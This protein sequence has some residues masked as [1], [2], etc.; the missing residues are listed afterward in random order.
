MKSTLAILIFLSSFAYADDL[1]SLDLLNNRLS[2]SVPKGAKNEAR[3]H[4]IMAAPEANESETRLVFEDGEK[5]LVVMAWELFRR[6]SATYK[7]EVAKAL[8]QWSEIESA[9]FKIS[10]IGEHITLGIPAE[11]NAED[12]AIL[13]AAA[14]VRHDDGTIQRIGVYFNPEF[15]KTPDHCADLAMKI[16]NSIKAGKRRLDLRAGDRNLDVLNDG[17]QMKLSV[18]DGWT[19]TTQQGVDFLVHNLQEVSDF[20]SSYASIGV[21]IG[22]HPSY[23]HSRIRDDSL[24]KEIRKAPLFGKSREWIEYST[25]DSEGWR[26]LEIISDVPGIDDYWKTHIFTGGTDD[27]QREQLLKII[28]TAKIEKRP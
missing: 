25:N 4:S 28:S 13:Y 24:I 5:K 14:F 12:D 1:E 22:G 20:G 2:I 10:T 16:V 21:Y 8:K 18:P 7:E 11:P 26:G 23:H 6:A 19:Y 15:H 3:G 27:K 17:F 9:P